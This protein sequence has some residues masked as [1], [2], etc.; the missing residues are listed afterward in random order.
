ML[1]HPNPEWAQRLSEI[2]VAHAQR[3][4]D[5]LQKTNQAFKVVRRGINGA[6]RSRVSVVP[7][8]HTSRAME[9]STTLEEIESVNDFVGKLERINLPNQLV[10]VLGDPLLQKLVQLKTT[11]II[12]ERINNWLT[13]YFEDILLESGDSIGESLD[14]L[15]SIREYT[16]FTK[17]C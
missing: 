1:Q 10:A 16:R 2:Q 6:K 13:A 15:D 14:L 12:Q 4:Q 5:G 11:P 17:V 8:V 9:S 7:E 3:S